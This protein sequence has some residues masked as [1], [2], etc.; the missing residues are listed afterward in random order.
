MQ[1]GGGQYLFILYKHI[2]L[3]FSKL[4]WQKWTDVLYSVIVKM[5]RYCHLPPLNSPHIQRP[6]GGTTSSLHTRVITDDVQLVE[7]SICFPPPMV[8]GLGEFC[9][10]IMTVLIRMHG[11]DTLLFNRTICRNGKQ[12]QKKK[13]VEIIMLWILRVQQFN[14]IFFYLFY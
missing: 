14:I 1:S 8:F 6:A 11:V 9:L 4:S 7:H 12:K 2:K 5:Y 13:H 3:I 10:S